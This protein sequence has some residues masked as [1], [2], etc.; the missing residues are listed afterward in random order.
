MEVKAKAITR[1]ELRAMW[2]LPQSLSAGS[3]MGK[4]DTFVL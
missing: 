1:E 4:E 3:E 2:T